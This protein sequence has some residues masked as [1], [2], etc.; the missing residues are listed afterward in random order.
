MASVLLFGQDKYEF[1]SYVYYDQ[2]NGHKS[3]HENYALF[4][5]EKD[6]IKIEMQTYD[7]HI[8]HFNYEILA[9]KKDGKHNVYYETDKGFQFYLDKRVGEVMV[10]HE[11]SKLV[12]IYH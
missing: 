8:M 10:V 7:D 5:F 1:S 11:K 6:S 3:V 12:S 2:M 9:Q 4:T